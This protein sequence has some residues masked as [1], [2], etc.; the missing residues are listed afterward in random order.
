V[1]K[2]TCFRDNADDRRLMSVVWRKVK[3]AI[4]VGDLEDI[5]KKDGILD[6]YL[7]SVLFGGLRDGVQ[8]YG[9]QA[10]SRTYFDKYAET[11]TVLE[12]AILVQLLNA[13]NGLNPWVA[14]AKARAQAER[15]LD[16][17]VR[18]D[19]LR[20][21]EALPCLTKIL[22]SSSWTMSCSS[23]HSELV[24]VVTPSPAG[25]NVSAYLS[26]YVRDAACMP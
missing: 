25:A 23:G 26:K 18:Q 12:G 16:D 3:E 9:I 20:P 10:A 17:M 21:A 7:N 8:V 6:V 13:P 15:L 1:L 22:V 24:T 2:N 11:L 5:L 19:A 4:T 14:P